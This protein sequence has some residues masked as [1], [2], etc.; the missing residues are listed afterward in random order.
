MGR[1]RWLQIDFDLGRVDA[2][3]MFVELG[4]T[5]ASSHRL[6]L[7]HFHDQALSD[8]ADAV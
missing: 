7:G 3:R 2:F 6:H 8:Q 1:R 4:A 5:R